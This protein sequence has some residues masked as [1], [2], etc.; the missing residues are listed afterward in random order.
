MIIITIKKYSK[1]PTA[2]DAIAYD[3]YLEDNSGR[4]Q[5]IRVDCSKTLK[6][7]WEIDDEDKLFNNVYP[8][9]RKTIIAAFKEGIAKNINNIFPMEFSTYNSPSKS[10]SEKYELPDEIEIEGISDDTGK[11]AVFISHVSGDKH[12]AVSLK[13]VLS[14]FGI[15]S[16]VAHEDIEEGE[17]WQAKITEWIENTTV[18]VILASKEIEMSPWVNFEIGLA[19]DKMFPFILEKLTDKVSY[20]KNKQGIVLDCSNTNKSILRLIK[21]I[22]SKLGLSTNKSDEEITTQD[23]FDNLKNLIRKKYCC[24]IKVATRETG[25]KISKKREIEI[26]YEDGVRVS[27]NYSNSRLKEIKSS[28]EGK[29][30]FFMSAT[31]IPLIEDIIDIEDK[32]IK[33]LMLRPTYNR[34]GG[35]NMGFTS[36]INDLLPTFD[37]IEKNLG[38]WSLKLFRNAHL[39]F[40][41]EVDY[42][43]SWNQPR[44]DFHNKPRFNLHAITEFPVS[45]IRFLKELVQL[46]NLQDSYRI[47]MA[48]LNCGEYR[49]RPYAPH[50]IGY[51]IGEDEIATLNKW[52]V[53][54]EIKKLNPENDEEAFAFIE[55][56]YHTFHMNRNQ[57]PYFNESKIF[58]I[59]K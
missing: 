52:I 35:W 7:I 38:T 54:K 15:K 16:F 43:F 12:I 18:M 26:S 46:K 2:K 8:L 31:P 10:P 27:I 53:T 1:V 42:Y 19:Y 58:E 14:D 49:L 13:D 57:I 22:L 21:T 34:S 28:I 40:H 4:S 50:N 37:G 24:G 44:E 11:Y 59:K 55:R 9:I 5:T 36:N 33:N 25:T 51:S 30:Y 20:V 56:L 41:A 45:F 3:V 6:E 47:Q 23:S 32:D 48:F 17:F 29:K 39:E